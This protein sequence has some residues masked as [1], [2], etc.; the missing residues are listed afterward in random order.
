MRAP[1]DTAEAA[2]GETRTSPEARRFRPDIQGLR[3]VSILLVVLFHAD[4]PVISGGYVGVDVF[5]VISGFVITGV[6]LR[7]RE[8][9]GRTSILNFY[10]RR[11]RRIIP[12]ASLVIVVTV[13]AA[14]HSLGSLVGHETAVDGQWA[15]LFLAN[16]HF[17][18]SATNYLASQ[19]PPS[20]LQNYWSLAVEE[21]FYIV[22]PTVFLIATGFITRMSLRARLAI[23]LVT[24]IVTSYAFSIVFTSA[25]PSSAF[26]SPLT[27]AWELALGG[28]IAVAGNRLRQM[29][30]AL[31]VFISWL[32]LAAI[33]TA[34][35]TLT[36]ATAYPG[37]LVA[38]PVLGAGLVL[39]GGA[40]HPTW[41]AERLL[42]LKPFQLLGLISY[43]LYLWHWPIL[44]IATQSRGVTS[45]PIWDN[46]LLLLIATVLA[47]VTY[48]LLEN[49]IRHS[50]FL[51][52]RRWASVFLGACLIAA[53][54]VVTTYEKQRPTVD[55]GNLASAE[56]G[57][58]CPS[59]TPS[60]V[61]HLRSTFRSGH[62]RITGKSSQFESAVVI[63]DSTSCSLLPGLQ[64]VGPSYEIGFKNAVVVGCGV[65]SGEIAPL[66]AFN[67]VNLSAPTKECQGIANSVETQAI[68]RYR[69]RLIIWGST[70]E[71]ES[72]VK[73]PASGNQV[74]DAGSAQWRSVMLQRMDD[75]VERFL[76]TGARVILLSE[77][78][79]VH[80]SGT[81]PDA[82][83]MK[84]EQMNALLRE[85][86]ARHRDKVA[87]VDLAAR[88]CPSGPPCPYFVSGFKPPGTA[89]S[90]V[91]AATSAGIRPD[92]IHYSA[93]SSLWVAEWL[94]PRIA[95]TGQSLS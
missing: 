43:S 75:R 23:V 6:L 87:V 19:Q 95:A 88:V 32:G 29:P 62:P 3:A 52:R 25:N 68:E 49:P 81:V 38:I 12:A 17:S 9:T 16:F 8:A 42:R 66:Y 53:T 85:V 2:K 22:Y 74:V 80:G 48:L 71:R 1:I 90:A 60:V 63:G 59:P 5:F 46:V 24:V 77:P 65:V 70:D 51:R 34:A 26:F 20:A 92:N 56:L 61:S 27:R 35:V 91:A 69:P 78:P 33:L 93:A 94:V 82:N 31:A 47:A 28:L 11:A 89:S 64:A 36:S 14:F 50:R 73:D 39:A 44:I 54:L 10:G 40:S 45:L 13:V 18:A 7:E 21:Q 37:S 41:G 86:A 58:R 76:A 79:S 4:I 15:T 67:G 84:Y 72:I 57:S 55:L 30:K 83:D